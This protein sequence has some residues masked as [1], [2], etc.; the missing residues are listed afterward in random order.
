MRL[1]VITSYPENGLTHGQKTVGVAS[2]TKNT[3]DALTKA[4]PTIRPVVWAETN[5]HWKRNSLL[6][7]LHLSL[8]LV[9]TNYDHLL[10][11]HEFNMFGSAK[12][13]LV[14]PLLQLINRLK[15][16]PST[17]VLHQVIADFGSIWKHAGFPRYAALFI[18]ILAKFY[19]FLIILL[20]QK[21]IVF[22][23]FL[24]KRLSRHQQSKITVIPH[25]VQKFVT[26]RK[27]YKTKYFNILFFGYLAQ[28]KGLEL[29]IEAFGQFVKINPNA[30]LTIA[31]GPNPNH[32]SKPFYQKY[33]A[34]LRKLGD[35]PKIT[36][37]GFVKQSDIPALFSLTDLVVLPYQ[38]A[39]SASGPL[40]L[41]L[42][43]QKPFI[44]SQ[45]LSV[46]T[47]TTDFANALV[48]NKLYT[49]DIVFLLNPTSLQKKLAELVYSPGK[50]QNIQQLSTSLYSERA[51]SKI[52]YRY[53]S[54]FRSV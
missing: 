19:Y 18:N 54:I 36:R 48:K 2:Y 20:S 42:S 26:P 29:L 34:S 24:K 41:A 51:W 5:N 30:R 10:L 37:T 8:K 45:P 33:L 6:S 28:Y 4:D 22:D 16:K 17:L 1:L 13:V 43:F 39:M 7:L 12:T 15:G 23:Q 47:Q 11:P 32:L 3:I 49:K 38:T 52:A 27:N 31:G 50:L 9:S 44:L 46:Y 53:L 14:F 25:A 35:D 40:S 21:T